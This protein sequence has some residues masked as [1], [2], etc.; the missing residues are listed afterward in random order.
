MD[1][2]TI[3]VYLAIKWSWRYKCTRYLS[4]GL[5][6]Y[7]AQ[8][9]IQTIL[10]HKPMLI[11]SISIIYKSPHFYFIFFY[12]VKTV[13]Y[14]LTMTSHPLNHRQPAWTNCTIFINNLTH[15]S[16]QCHMFWAWLLQHLCI[17]NSS[18][19]TWFHSCRWPGFDSWCW[20]GKKVGGWSHR[21]FY[22]WPDMELRSY[23]SY[24]STRPSV[25]NSVVGPCYQIG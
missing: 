19:R 16:L 17:F 21:G 10:S 13:K 12:L 14:F 11:S 25:E 20:Q 24:W 5:R 6:I 9:G 3:N 23:T 15:K 2:L 22:T 4:S 1:S 7:P 18:T 8:S